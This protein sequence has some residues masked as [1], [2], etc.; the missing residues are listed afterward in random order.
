[1]L[2]A[3]PWRIIPHLRGLA[4]ARHGIQKASWNNV[5]SRVR[6]ALQ[7]SGARVRDGR[8]Q[9]HLQPE[10]ADIFNPL[11]HQFKAALGGFMSWC[12]EM[13]IA[14]TQVSQDTFEQYEAVLEQSR[15]RKAARRTFLL[16]RRTWNGAV[17]QFPYWP[18]AKLTVKY[19]LDHRYALPWDAFDSRF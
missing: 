10:W 18:R 17:E 2:D 8:R 5:V 3:A 16:T 13:G 7:A 6:K 9:T 14:P 11:P 1:N 12:C 19:K 4:H 15:M